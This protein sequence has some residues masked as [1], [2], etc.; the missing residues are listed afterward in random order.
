MEDPTQETVALFKS[1]LCERF[2]SKAVVTSPISFNI[3]LADL[4]QKEEEALATY[5]RRATTL[6]QR[7]GSRDRP[8][9]SHTASLTTL[10][11]AM[12]DTILHAFIKWLHDPAI[13]MAAAPSMVS[14]TRSLRS[15][16]I[17]AEEARRVNIEIERCRP[18]D[19]QPAS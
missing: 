9:S 6:M 12:L 3:E 5:Y 17:T 15:I 1:L 7:T 10:E 11:A 2:P 19:G 14:P 18:N 4:R 16:Y 8:A 13:R